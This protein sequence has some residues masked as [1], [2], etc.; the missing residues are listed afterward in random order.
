[1]SL[2][3][4]QKKQEAPPAQ[5]PPVIW[6]GDL[7]SITQGDV[8][9]TMSLIKKQK[10]PGIDLDYVNKYVN[11]YVILQ[12]GTEDEDMN[13]DMP[14]LAEFTDDEDKGEV[15]LNQFFCWLDLKPASS[16]SS[17]ASKTPS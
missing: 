2:I 17:L 10:T 5:D 9:E 7:A 1:M 3:K 13:K 4:K 11:K 12:D 6:F 15:R 8:D 14:P 16:L